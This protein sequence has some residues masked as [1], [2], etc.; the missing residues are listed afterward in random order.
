VRHGTRP[1]STALMFAKDS[2]LPFDVSPLRALP[3]ALDSKGRPAAADGDRVKLAETLKGCRE[4]AVDSPVFQ[5][6]QEF[7]KPDLAH[8]KTDVFRKTPVNPM[9]PTRRSPAQ[10][11]TTA[12]SAR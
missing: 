3:Y 2:S 12:G 11:G 7:P 6:V 4:K 9:V 8:L 5:L 1:F 10:G